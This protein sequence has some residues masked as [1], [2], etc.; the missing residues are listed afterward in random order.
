MW[1]ME[2]VCSMDVFHCVCDATVAKCS[3][4]D[5]AWQSP[6]HLRVSDRSPCFKADAVVTPWLNGRNKGYGLF[7]FWVTTR[8]TGAHAELRRSKMNYFTVYKEKFFNL[9]VITT[10]CVN[11]LFWTQFLFSIS[12]GDL[13]VDLPHWATS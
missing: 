10:T 1:L 4:N 6:N 9:K 8:V 11:Y 5:C 2:S 3:S 12:A 7:N 13:Y